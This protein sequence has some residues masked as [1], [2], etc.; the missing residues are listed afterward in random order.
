MGC[1]VWKTRRCVVIT[2]SVRAST[3]PQQQILNR[4]QD[5]YSK[6]PGWALLFV[7]FIECYARCIVLYVLI[8]GVAFE[9]GGAEDVSEE[10]PT[11]ERT[12][13]ALCM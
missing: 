1:G 9:S 12:G 3:L 4:A 2:G 10:D 8:Y 11:E 6:Q 5:T 13:E 7:K